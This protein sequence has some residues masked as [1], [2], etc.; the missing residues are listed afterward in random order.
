MTAMEYPWRMRLVWLLLLVAASAVVWRLVDLN[1]TERSFLMRQGD[2]R[3][4][5]EVSIPAHRG[6]ILDCECSGC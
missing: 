1:L 3:M 5:R 2:A 6:M 4:V